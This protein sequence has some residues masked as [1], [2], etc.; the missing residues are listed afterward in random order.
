MDYIAFSNS[1]LNFMMFDLFNMVKGY[2]FMVLQ[3]ADQ[4]S[5]PSLQTEIAVIAVYG[6]KV[7]NSFLL[8]HRTPLR[9][10][11]KEKINPLE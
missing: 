7:D 4:N 8:L 10:K 9:R 3:V 1:A 2:S 5:S 6:R 11:K